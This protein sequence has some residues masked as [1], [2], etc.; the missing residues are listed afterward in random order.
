L[1]LSDPGAVMEPKAQTPGTLVGS[2]VGHQT[3]IF[4]GA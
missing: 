2:Y 3:I 1:H 4:D